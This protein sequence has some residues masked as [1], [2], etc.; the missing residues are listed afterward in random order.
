MLEILQ[1]DCNRLGSLA[2]R[3]AGALEAIATRRGDR[4]GDEHFRAVSAYVAAQRS[5]LEW[6]RKIIFSDKVVPAA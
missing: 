6:S 1:E 3:A 2:A 5:H 4:A